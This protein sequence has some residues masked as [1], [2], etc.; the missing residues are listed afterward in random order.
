MNDG[1]PVQIPRQDLNDAGFMISAE[2]QQA[3][4]AQLNTTPGPSLLDKNK[5]FP[6]G[7]PLPGKKPTFNAIK[8]EKGTI[9]VIHDKAVLGKGS[10]GNVVVA[11]VIHSADTSM[12]E[13]GFCAVKMQQLRNAK[14]I[15]KIAKEDGIGKDMGLNL[16][17]FAV[18]KLYY[19]VMPVL[20]GKT[21]SKSVPSYVGNFSP[22]D[23]AQTPFDKPEDFNVL[24]FIN[25]FQRMTNAVDYLH[26]AGIIHLDIKPDNMIMDPNTGEIKLIDFGTSKRRNEELSPPSS[27]AI[28]TPAYMASEIFDEAYQSALSTKQDIYSLARTF[29]LLMYGNMLKMN[30]QSYEER[31]PA[32]SLNEYDLYRSSYLKEQRLSNDIQ[33]P[34]I[35][36]INDLIDLIQVMRNQA[37]PDRRPEATEIQARLNAISIKYQNAPRQSDYTTALT[38][39]EKFVHSLMGDLKNMRKV[40]SKEH[41]RRIT[42][43]F[44]Q[45]GK[46]DELTQVREL[47]YEID[48]VRI[49]LKE[50][51]YFDAEAVYSQVDSVVKKHADA[52]GNQAAKL[53]DKI[54]D[55]IESR[56]ASSERS[57]LHVS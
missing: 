52:N 8:D 7:S 13:G 31:A 53:C 40:H 17:S 37:D 28:G 29:E 25:L 5:A 47:L 26:Q 43:M 41:M 49:A 23:K 33:S 57:K 38:E 30:A 32:P 51:R 15:K 19:S 2:E 44:E 36:A 22:E 6:E 16:S 24:Y 21:L 39:A 34:D 46:N 1:V 45:H 18:G 50:N 54:H 56:P 4:I 20:H 11:Q 10:F 14:M 42:P 12:K 55:F 48:Q 3:I 9:L 35:E 27:E